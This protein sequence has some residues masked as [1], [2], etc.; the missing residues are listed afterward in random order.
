MK[1]LR[2]LL[3][4]DPYIPVPPRLYGGIERVVD[5]LVRGL[6][7]RGHLVTL[8]AHPASRTAGRL[9]P[10]GAPPH[11]G[12]TPRATE[13]WQAGSALWAHR[14][15]VDLVHSFGRLAALVPLLPLRRLPKI[16]SY[17][18]PEVPWRSVAIASALAGAS[19]SFTSCSAS[20]FRRRPPGASQA[21]GRWRAIFNGI[22]LSRYRFVEAVPMDAP[23]V[24]LGKIEPMKGVHDAIAIAKIAERRLVIAGT[25]AESGPDAEYFE[26]EIAPYI[27]GGQVTFLGPVDDIQKSDLL[28]GACALV[29]PTHWEETFGLVMVEAMACG[30]PV[31]G[32]ARGA[33]PEVV[34]EGVNGYLCRSVE[35]AVAAVKRLDL[36]DR[37]AVRADCEARFSDSDMVSAY[38]SLYLDMVER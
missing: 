37:R 28:G 1:R 21:G 5:S 19:L 20:V 35:E 26:R 12:L 30:T 24:F 7:A 10:Y 32:F 29:F 16:Q 3:T 18:R 23:L 22:A 27:D 38:E 8:V 14:S 36:I 31:I 25:R 17:H 15:Q 9:I 6:H 2:I 34:Q 4:A 13:L 11:F 33:V